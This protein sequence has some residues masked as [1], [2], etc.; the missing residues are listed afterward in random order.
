MNKHIRPGERPEKFRVMRHDCTR[1]GCFEKDLRCRLGA[2]DHLLPG[3]NGMS[4]ADGFCAINGNILFLE[5]KT[6]GGVAQ[7]FAL[8]QL[9][10]TGV[11]VIARGNVQKMIPTKWD[12][13]RLG[14]KIAHGEGDNACVAFDLFIK[15]WGDWALKTPNSNIR[16]WQSDYA[17]HCHRKYGDEIPIWLL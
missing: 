12:A 4:D 11:V 8:K 14:K 9:S 7:M 1:D 17:K 10:M 6:G 15:K 5:W 2:L 16:D 3:N 13:W